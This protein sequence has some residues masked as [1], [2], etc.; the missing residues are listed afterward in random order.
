MHEVAIHGVIE[1]VEE[2]V[3]R[4]VSLGRCCLEADHL[5]VSVEVGESV[6]VEES[7]DGVAH[8]PFDLFA[9]F[10]VVEEEA[11]D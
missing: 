6:V 2:G 4:L 5:G 11:Q 1:R 10:A 3:E 8:Y 7:G 9:V